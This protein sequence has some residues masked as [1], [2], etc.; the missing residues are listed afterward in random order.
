MTIRKFVS[1]L[2]N[3]IRVL[4]PSQAYALW[5]PNYDETDNN[6]VILTEE[7]ILLPIFDRIGFDNKRIIDFGCGT[8]RHITHCLNRNASEILGIDI[9]EAML[10]VARKKFKYPKVHFIQSGLDAIPILSSIFDVGIASLVLSHLNQLGPC[11]R[12]MG[13]VL[14]TGARLLITDIHWSFSERGWQRTFRP[15][16]LPSRRFAP[17][18]YYHTFFDFQ[19]AFDENGFAMVTHSEPA[20]NPTVRSCFERS[21]M[22]QVYERYLGKPLMVFFE[23]TKR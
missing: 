13:R 10:S 9:S 15:Q 8:G 21:N 11:L 14:K 23:V 22:I 1:N 6:A 2:L 3:P 17:A 20:L 18:S 4:P 5:A 16:E 12:E 19:R 7:Q